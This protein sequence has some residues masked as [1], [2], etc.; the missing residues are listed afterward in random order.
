M[1]ITLL[2][3]SS[4][5]GFITRGNDPDIYKWT[6][7]EDQA[8]FFQHIEKA[9]LIF[10]G[11][12]TYEH[13]KHLM[14]H[15]KGRTRIVFTHAPERYSSERIPDVLEFTKKTPRAVV[16]L[17]EKRGINRALVVGGQKINSL[18]LKQKLISELLLTVE[19]FLF[20]SGKKLCIDEG[21]FQMNLQS[22]KKINKKGTFLLNYSI[23]SS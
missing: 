6:S 15:K 10:M 20:G 16:A 23:T 5:D 12:K 3:V 2:A 21:R 9:Q 14:K 19:P 8:S 11:S 7:R 13:A 4:L 17:Y 18:F 1:K 22:I